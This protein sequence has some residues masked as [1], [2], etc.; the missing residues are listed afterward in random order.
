MS[1][2]IWGKMR[3][4]LWLDEAKNGKKYGKVNRKQ[5]RNTVTT[6]V[7]ILKEKCSLEAFDF[8]WYYKNYLFSTL[9]QKV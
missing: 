7:L 4:N 6:R 2:L 5:T 3:I 8:I 9:F 1:L